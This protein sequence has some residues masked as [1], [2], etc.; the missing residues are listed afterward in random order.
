MKKAKNRTTNKVIYVPRDYDSQLLID[1]QRYER[2][3][4]ENPPSEVRRKLKITRDEYY[5]IYNTYGI[6]SE[7]P[8]Q[9][10]TE[11]QIIAAAILHRD[12]KSIY[13]MAS[14]W[15]VDEKLLGKKVKF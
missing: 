15:G 1:R 5:T 6:K 2:I 8:D 12:G 14:E 7:L 4:R 13:S 3:C 11:L 9:A 10:P